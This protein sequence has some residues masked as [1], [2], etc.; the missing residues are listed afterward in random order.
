MRFLA[1]VLSII[2]LAAALSG[3]SSTKH[4]PE[5]EYL[6][7]RVDIRVKDG[8]EIETE[9]LYN[10]LR[11]Q[12]NHKVLGFAKLQLATYSL[13]GRDSTKWYNRWL[14][15]VGQAPVIYDPELT[16][17]SARQLRQALVNRGYM[18]ARVVTDTTRR[19]PKRM[20]VEYGIYA[21]QPHYIGSID[22]NIP[23]S[24]VRRIVL[25]D[26]TVTDG[27][28]P[29]D[30]FD[31]NRLDEERGRI[32]DLLRNAG[33][34][35]INRDCI[36]YTADTAANSKTVGLT[37][38]LRAPG[39]AGRPAAAGSGSDETAP[40]L[41]KPYYIGR[42]FLVVANNIGS[43][44]A[45]RS[46]AA[47]TKLDTVARRGLDI[48][49]GT[50]PF[51]RP[52]LLEEKCY[53]EPGM[54]YR[55]RAVDRT[56]E[57]LGRLSIVKFVNI[58]L[59]PVSLPGSPTGL[60]DAYVFISRN[61]KQSVSLELE[62]TN[63]EGDLG[64]GVG[65]TYQH[66]N[67]AR[68][69]ELLTAKFRT[70]YESLSGNVEGLI[71]N[72]YSEYA[73]EVGITFPKFECPFLTRNFK[74]RV[75]ASTEFAV[76]FN[77]QERPEYTRIIAGAAWKWKWQQQRP[78]FMRRHT[79]DLVDINYVRLP[80]STYDFINQ[81]A[82]DN[83]LLRY[84]YE[85]HFIMRMGYTYYRTNRRVPTA[86]Q[87]AFSIQP[88]VTTVRA[89]IETAGNL[90]YAISSAVGQ[91]RSDGVYK[92][93][94]IQYAQY[95]KGE[96]DYTYTRNLNS[97]NAL[98]LHAGLGIAY[99]YGNSTM[100]PFEKRFY[101]GG[102]NG[103]RGWGV[104]TLGPGA[105]DA[106]N[107]VTDFINQCG[108]ISLLMN[109]EY[110]AKLFW[111]FEGALFVDAGNIWTIRNYETQPRGEFKFDKFYKQIALAYGVGLRMDFT[112]FL[113]RFDL[114]MKA[115]NPAANQEPWPLLHPRWG[116]DAN[117]HFSVGY[118]F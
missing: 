107:S 116:R 37:L 28:E 13:S 52:S 65:L 34:Y 26:T 115:H 54:R 69:S 94:G 87:S 1:R 83:P 99:P 56:Y 45:L 24:A 10:F 18:D 67:L 41:N 74:K 21:G 40:V 92:V 30:L 31:R 82:P 101:A 7:D 100:V 85:D 4:V 50:D 77:Y 117:F 114:G 104:R 70:A 68:G 112:Y 61:K 93:L 15:R 111:V 95:V 86:Q 33:Y 55:A 12:P 20:A 106:R 98:S 66:R 80:R 29:G 38:N 59:V 27:L 79:Y 105:F 48:I 53:L 103:V 113:L 81:I 118:P 23:D 60:L 64:F 108:D 73:G 76:S 58:E 49:Y 57:A 63:S 62:G 88:Y 78:G 72:R 11:Q 46:A 44:D 17:A 36:T 89:S 9:E 97:R 109:V 32:V 110:R 35:E 14:R 42:V 90:L 8:E 22:Y 71:N 39:P 84:S 5:D 25:A 43:V 102:A 47:T 19:G 75:M 3:C 16:A 6:L 96:A 2:A 91:R 51:L